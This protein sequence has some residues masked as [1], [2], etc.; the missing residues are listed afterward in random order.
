[1]DLLRAVHNL[2]LGLF[3]STAEV[4]FGVRGMRVQIVKQPVSLYV[5]ICIK[6]WNI[7]CQLPAEVYQWPAGLEDFGENSK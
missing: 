3:S 1:M 7:P 6:T 2:K 5:Y 4:A